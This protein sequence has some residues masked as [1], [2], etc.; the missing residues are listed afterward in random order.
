MDDTTPDYAHRL[1]ILIVEDQEDSADTMALLVRSEGYS[2]NVARDGS[3]ALAAA[4]ASQ[5]H[6][7]LLD[8][9]LP[10]LD[11]WEVARRLAASDDRTAKWVGKDALRELTKK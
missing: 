9:G 2:A 10:G 11:G 8:I 7:I 6:V 1:R 4:K 5:P 3:A